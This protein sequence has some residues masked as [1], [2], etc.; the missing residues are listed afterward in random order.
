MLRA[1]LQGPQ[2]PNE[3]PS[4]PGGDYGDEKE[5][6]GPI[7]LDETLR[8]LPAKDGSQQADLLLEIPYLHHLTNPHLSKEHL[9]AH[10][11]PNYESRIG[12]ALERPHKT[13]FV[14][15]EGMIDDLSTI[16]YQIVSDFSLKYS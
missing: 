16:I 4:D 1:S 3:P 14:T 5:A 6:D 7:D 10:A 8:E 11:I 2:E 13:S 15:G 9:F 12:I